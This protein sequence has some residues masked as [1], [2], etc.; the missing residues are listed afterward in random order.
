MK[1][2]RHLKFM[3]LKLKK[4]DINAFNFI[5][6][7]ENLLNCDGNSNEF[8]KEKIKKRNEDICKAKKNEDEKFEKFLDPSDY[9]LIIK[10][11]IPIF[12]EEEYKK[13]GKLID[14]LDIPGLDEGNTNFDNFIIPI[15]KNILFPI[16]I[17]DVN[18][19]SNDAPKIII[20]QFLV[21]LFKIIK[22]K[23]IIEKNKSFELGFYIL[24]KIDLINKK[25]K[26]KM[27]LLIILNKF[28]LKLKQI[29]VMKY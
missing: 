22:S 4:R 15:F 26:K 29:R 24:N 25:Q 10:T 18:S 6:K 19:Y 1:I 21:Q 27:K 14:F 2:F 3:K 28:F 5:E 12:E 9:F 23:Y 11:K 20:K 16:F 7:G 8:L 13:Y 17:F